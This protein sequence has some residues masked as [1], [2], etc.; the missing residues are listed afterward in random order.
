MVE[1]TLGR[2]VE[3]VKAERPVWNTAAEIEHRTGRMDQIRR[4]S[5]NAGGLDQPEGRMRSAGDFDRNSQGI[6]QQGMLEGPAPAV[7]LGRVRRPAME[8]REHLLSR[9]GELVAIGREG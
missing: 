3:M 6:R 9:R 4:S 2:P 8:L 7:P 5:E 1:G